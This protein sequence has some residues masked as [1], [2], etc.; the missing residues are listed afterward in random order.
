MGD[1]A[2][3]TRY[4]MIISQRIYHPNLAHHIRSCITGGYIYQMFKHGKQ[5]SRPWQKRINI[6]TP[7]LTSFIWILNTCLG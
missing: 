5:T 6:I 3:V 4:Y 7:T 1:H 2:G